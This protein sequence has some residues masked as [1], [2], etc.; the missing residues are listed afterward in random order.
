MVISLGQR[1]ECCQPSHLRPLGCLT[2]NLVLSLCRFYCI[3]YHTWGVISEKSQFPLV[4][5][6]NV[7]IVSWLISIAGLGFGPRHGFLYYTGFYIGLDSDSDPLIEMY[8]IGKMICPYNR[9][10][11]HLGKGSESESESKSMQWKHVL[12]NTM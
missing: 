2:L 8:V 12:H 11:N 4:E 10:S 9:Y 5:L 3:S 6:L 1:Y 7:I